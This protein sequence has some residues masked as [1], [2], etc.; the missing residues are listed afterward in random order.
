MCEEICPTQRKDDSCDSRPSTVQW[1][2]Y[3][4]LTA[5][6][7]VCVREYVQFKEKT[8]A[9]AVLWPSTMSYLSNFN[10]GCLR[11]KRSNSKKISWLGIGSSVVRL[12]RSFFCDGKVGRSFSKIDEIES[13][14]SIFKK[15]RRSK[16]DES[17]SIFWHKKVENR[18][19]H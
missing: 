12:N 10:R 8:I 1:V 9:V 13:I 5:V 4:T 11:E 17:N 6:Q 3:T 18:Q 15:D 7:R 16:I 14:P 2:T 19:K